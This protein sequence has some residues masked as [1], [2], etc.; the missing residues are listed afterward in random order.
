MCFANEFADIVVI[1]IKL[2]SDQH[3]RATCTAAFEL[4]YGTED[5]RTV[6]DLAN[7]KV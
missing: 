4:S 2:Y 6:V 1:V 7:N 3:C 5:L